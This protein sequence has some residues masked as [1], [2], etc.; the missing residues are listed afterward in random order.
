MAPHIAQNFSAKAD[1]DPEEAL[2]YFLTN[3][4]CLSSSQIT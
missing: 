3:A 1:V 2:P 4:K